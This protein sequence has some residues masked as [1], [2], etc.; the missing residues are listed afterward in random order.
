MN[1]ID[2][3]TRSLKNMSRAGALAAAAAAAI[4][5]GAATSTAALAEQPDAN[6][7]YEAPI[8]HRQPRIQ[9]LPSDVAKEE[10]KMPADDNA[11]DK[12]LETSI[13]RGC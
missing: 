9:D 10:K 5:A 8:G 11:L 4:L 7:R 3:S 1:R 12:K 2:R 6:L 13:C